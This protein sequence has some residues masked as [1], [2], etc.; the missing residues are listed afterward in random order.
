[1]SWAANSG[2][3]YGGFIELW[4]ANEPLLE[5]ASYLI[6]DGWAPTGNFLSLEAGYYWLLEVS[7]EVDYTGNSPFSNMVQVLP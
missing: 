5:E 2:S 4:Q 3:D 6:G 7:N 1:M